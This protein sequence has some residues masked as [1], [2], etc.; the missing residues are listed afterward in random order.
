MPKRRKNS[1]LV[2]FLACQ[3]KILKAILQHDI[4]ENKKLFDDLA[5][6]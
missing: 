5:R 2:V 1:V 4:N 3:K 6:L